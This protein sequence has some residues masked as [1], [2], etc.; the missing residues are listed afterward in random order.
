MPRVP[1]DDRDS[2]SDPARVRAVL[3]D[4]TAT[5]A[6]R[7][8][9]LRRLPDSSPEA[10]IEDLLGILGKKGNGSEAFRLAC[11]E[12][13]MEKAE[14]SDAGSK[15][16]PAIL[17]AL[18]P[19]LKSE[20]EGV[21]RKA[22]TLLCAV[23]H[24]AAIGLLTAVMDGKEKLFTKTEAINLLAEGDPGKHRAVLAK[25]LDDADSNV[26]AAA[27]RALAHVPGAG[28]ADSSALLKQSQDSSQPEELRLAILEAQAVKPS[29]AFIQAAIDIMKNTRDKPAVRAGAIA[30]LAKVA[31]LG[32]FPR[33]AET[34]VLN[35]IR[36][37]AKD[38][39]P[40]V[41]QAATEYLQ[42]FGKASDRK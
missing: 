37:L 40:A 11:L 19:L 13:L 22:A 18:V 12:H 21:R 1:G 31:N 39:A 29:D 25:G 6:Q 33:G 32:Q 41:R 26:Q 23:E 4:A 5:D 2:S 35:A 42:A 16:K 17:A 10:T 28:V 24:P 20:P 9:A 30:E 15:R 8:L 3:N 34:R 36:G 14:F 38:K 27:I 7:I